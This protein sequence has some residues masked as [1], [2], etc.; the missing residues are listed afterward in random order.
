ML[1][2]LVEVIKI[3]ES[4]LFLTGWGLLILIFLALLSSS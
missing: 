4:G 1:A 2:F 3:T